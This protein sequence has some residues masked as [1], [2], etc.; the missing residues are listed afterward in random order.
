MI[1][2][3][4]TLC[5][6]V[7]PASALAGNIADCELM[8]MKEVVDEAGGT[9]AVAAFPPAG[10]FLAGVYDDAVEL[11]LQHDGEPIRALM[12]TR[13]TV[14]PD[15]DD[16]AILATGI[17]LAVS[18]DFDSNQSDALTVFFRDGAFRYKYASAE[19]MPD[20]MRTTLEA[21]LA[22]FS[23]RDHGLGVPVE[24]GQDDATTDKKDVADGPASD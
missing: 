6:A 17:P 10:D 21:R 13:K 7:L 18:Q 24:T 8:T 14:M 1:R 9:M 2:A 23:A 11:S 12:C 4:L 5:L 19:D 20:A 16:Y 15:E 3:T 22:D